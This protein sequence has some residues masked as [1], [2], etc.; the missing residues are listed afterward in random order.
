[1]TPWPHHRRLSLTLPAHSSQALQ[2]RPYA[3]TVPLN[4]HTVY[5]VVV[6]LV[7]YYHFKQAGLQQHSHVLCRTIITQIL[8]ATSN[9][10]PEP[11]AAPYNFF[12]CYGRYQSG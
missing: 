3:G 1:M 9:D 2:C 6:W 4:T 7:W 8:A 10:T 11:A 5:T 12:S